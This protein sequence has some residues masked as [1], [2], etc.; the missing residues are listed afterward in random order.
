MS[1]NPNKSLF[2]TQI[3]FIG[4]PRKNIDLINQDNVFVLN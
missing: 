1:P 2:E 4:D 3:I